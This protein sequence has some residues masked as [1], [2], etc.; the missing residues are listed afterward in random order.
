MIGMAAARGA[1]AA[2]SCS[3]SA[4]GT[5]SANGIFKMGDVSHAVTK[6]RADSNNAAAIGARGAVASEARGDCVAV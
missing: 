6:L 1:P 3:S 4:I 2:A 5:N